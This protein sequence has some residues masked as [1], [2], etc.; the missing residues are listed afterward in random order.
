MK[1]PNDDYVIP[2]EQNKQVKFYYCGPASV[3]QSLSFHKTDSGIGLSLPS[4]EKIAFT[5]GTD[6]MKASTSAGLAKAINQYRHD[7]DF[8]DTPYKLGDIE[9]S[10]NPIGLLKS[11]VKASISSRT[12]APILLVETENMNRYSKAPKNYRHYVTVSGYFGSRNAMRIVDANHIV[13]NGTA[14]GGTYEENIGNG[15]T[16]GVGKAVLI[17]DKKGGNAAMLW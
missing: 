15:T 17:A 7:F 9:G 16:K 13:A 2:V 12:N 11:R 4:Q 3:R 14:F 5:A 1:Q 6:N 8:A 10:S